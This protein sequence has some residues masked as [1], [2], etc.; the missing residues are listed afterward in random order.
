MPQWVRKD[1]GWRLFVR[2]TIARMYPR[3][4]GANRQKAGM[5]LEVFLPFLSLAAYVLV[6]RAIGASA[7]VIGFVI[8]GG[9][10]MAFWLN[11]LWA[12][13]NQFFWERETGNLS[14]Y[15]MSP[16]SLMAILLGMAIGGLLNTMLRAAVIIVAGTW[17]FDVHMTVASNSQLLVVFV[18]VLIALYGMGM[19]FASL[20]LLYSRDA[21]HLIA[22][23]QEPVYLLSGLY[24]PMKNLNGWIAMGA[25]IIPL[26]LGLDAIRQLTFA[27]G[28]TFGL[29]DVRTETVMLGI[30]GIVFLV[31]ARVSLAYMEHRAITEGRLTESRG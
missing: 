4:I 19:M 27:S 7:T 26:T 6:C 5:F 23:A 14:L 8:L 29:M 20:F 25:S 12:M 10:M 9:A 30:L 11:V 24:F 31:G 18:L 3:L 17:L 2:T 16:S 21:W 1:T 28:P 15:I 13:A 22:L